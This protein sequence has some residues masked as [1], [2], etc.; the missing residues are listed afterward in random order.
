MENTPNANGDIYDMNDLKDL[1]RKAEVILL[2][3][4]SKSAIFGSIMLPKGNW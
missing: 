1:A 3:K 2:Q 4:G